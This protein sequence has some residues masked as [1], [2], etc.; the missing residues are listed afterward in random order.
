[1]RLCSTADTN[2]S[3]VH[4]YRRD[5]AVLLVADN[6]VGLPLGSALKETQEFDSRYILEAESSMSEV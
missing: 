4:R 1:M 5:R 3:A 2:E 6:A